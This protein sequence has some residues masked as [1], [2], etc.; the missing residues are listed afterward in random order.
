MNY[1]AAEKKFGEARTRLVFARPYFA[2]GVYALRLIVTPEVPS[3]AVDSWGRVYGNPGWIEQ[4]DVGQVATALSHE[5]QHVLFGHH[6]RARAVGVACDTMAIWNDSADC[7]INDGLVD[8]C[9]RCKPLLPELPPEWCVLP[10][11]FGLPDGKAAEWY[12]A[13]RVRERRERARSGRG[14]SKSQGFGC[15]SGAT[16]VIAPWESGSP[17]SSDVDG[18]DEADLWNM[19]RGVAMAIKD[20]SKHGGKN[21]GSAPAGLLEWADELLRPRRISWEQALASAMRRASL[22]TAG[23]VRQSYARPSRRQHAFGAVVMPAYR[24]PVPNVAFVSDTSMSM[25]EEQRALVRGVVDDA[26]RHLSVP[27]RVIDVDAKVHRDVMVSSGRLASRMGRGGTDM[28]VGI[29]AAFRRPRPADAA[30]VCTDCETEWPKQKTPGHLIVA[31]VG[32]SDESIAAI[33][34]WATVIRVEAA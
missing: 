27:L 12:F 3:F 5:L 14:D 19:R 13:E 22:T 1:P 15:G 16:G 4:H 25:N 32:A 10:K 2:Q 21:R 17:E 33:P 28:C 18:L 24:R 11:H 34:S 31:A 26:C 30:V 29:E 23:A 6:A 8:D 20:F 9:R 7:D